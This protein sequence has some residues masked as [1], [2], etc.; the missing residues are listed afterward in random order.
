MH[1][2]QKFTLAWN[3]KCFRQFLCPSS[4]VY[5]L[6]SRTRMELQF[7]SGP[8]W[9]IPLLSV[10]WIN[11][12]W[13]AEE[14]SEK[15]RVSCQN[16]FVEL[17]HL[18]VFI[19]KKYVMMHEHKKKYITFFPLQIYKIWGMTYILG[20]VCI[21]HYNDEYCKFTVTILHCVLFFGIEITVPVML[22]S[23]KKNYW[24]FF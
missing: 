3:S 9:H 21:L 22:I 20:V 2:F 14:L 13:W 1:E 18:V 12:Q 10:Q 11:S 5:S 16:K 23:L 24:N 4:G 15:C 7:Q 17:V 8:V 19:I 6:S